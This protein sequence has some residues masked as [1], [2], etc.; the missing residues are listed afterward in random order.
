[1]LEVRNITKIYKTK[2]ANDVYALNNVSL[3]FGDK[4]MIFLLGK[5]GSGKSTLLNVIGGLDSFDNGEIIINGRSSK[6]FKTGDFDAYRNT[7]LGFIFQE[8]NILQDFS[9]AKNIALSLELQG[10]KATHSAVEDLLREVDLGGMGK[11]KPAQLS[12]GQKQRIA[13]ARALIKNPDVILADEP[14][15]AL[16]SNT[17]RQVFET[18]KKLS[19]DKLVIVVSHDRENAE[20]FADRII[21]LKDGKVIADN[22]KRFVTPKTVG[23]LNLISNDLLQLKNTQNL[24]PALWQKIG[25]KVKHDGQEVLI[26]SSKELNS[27]VKKMA[28]ISDS[29]DREVF[30]ETLPSDIRRGS[31]GGNFKLIKGKFRFKDSVKMGAS[32][33]KHKKVRLVFTIILSAIALAFFGLAN[34]MGSFSPQTSMYESVKNST[35]QTFSI[36]GVF[37]ENDGYYSESSLGLIDE[38]REYLVDTYG[39]K[40]IKRIGISRTNL[41]YYDDQFIEDATTAYIA[42]NELMKKHY[43]LTSTSRWPAND[44]ECLITDFIYELYKVNGYKD[45]SGNSNTIRKEG[46][47]IG[48]TIKNNSRDVT[49]VGILKTDFDFEKYSKYFDKDSQNSYEVYDKVW[50]LNETNIY[51]SIIIGENM[52]KAFEYED[53]SYNKFSANII[54]NSN[55]PEIFSSSS[56]FTLNKTSYSTALNNGEI[57]KIKNSEYTNSDVIVSIVSFD[58]FRSIVYRRDSSGYYSLEINNNTT[59]DSLTYTALKNEIKAYYDLNYGDFSIVGLNQMENSINHKIAGIYVPQLEKG[60]YFS[61]YSYRSLMFPTQTPKN[62]ERIASNCRSFL[63]LETSN[64]KA[65]IMDNYGNK[66]VGFHFAVVSQFNDFL[67]TYGNLI[68]TLA[69][70]FL[71]ASLVFAVFS[72]FLLMTFIATSISFKKKEIGIL[73]A[74]GAKGRDVYGIFLNESMIISFINF[75]ISVVLTLGTVIF[76]NRYF[77]SKIGV[78]IQIMSF[79]LHQIV[80]MLGISI[81]VAIIATFLPVRKIAKMKPIDA[82]TGRK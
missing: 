14:T 39:A 29:G 57:I 10:K 33:L 52:E 37:G 66:T 70:V 63:V 61:S 81:L 58:E 36:T 59:T 69:E 19:K 44:S 35:S 4:G 55:S 38:D 26:I 77:S 46:D 32:G 78:G 34:T 40:M 64:L 21:E 47:I 3:T 17:G 15:G 82:I 62:V 56:S 80:L 79:G 53:S 73:R 45:S 68:K 1:M 43:E 20:Q 76:L 28:R 24:N 13:I 67:D 41:C 23:D 31:A 25:E 75:V 6:T 60:E 7:Y 5:S 22:T 9:V 12:G 49:I 74:L 48:K 65:M 71:Y 27:Q 50:K 51:N 42:D 11:R 72:A 54:K 2:Q 30:N 8:Y 18:L 16:D